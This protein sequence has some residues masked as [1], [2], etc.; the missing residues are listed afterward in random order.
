MD[1]TWLSS[2]AQTLHN[3]FGN[4]FYLFMTVLLLIGVILEYFKF[5]IGGTPQF[6]VLVGRCFIAALLLVAL[7]EVMD[8]LAKFTDSVVK[9]LGAFNVMHDVLQALGLK[10]KS[11]TWSWVGLKDLV[12]VAISA[13]SFFALYVTVYVGDAI[14]VYSWILLYVMSPVLIA[15]YVLPATAGATSALFKS[16]IHVCAWKILWCVLCSLMW[17]FALSDINKPD[18]S[19]NFLTAI[20]VNLMLAISVLMVPKV[21]SGFLSGGISGVADGIGNTLMNAASLTPSSVA[22][23]AMKPVRETK[24]FGKQALMGFPK[25]RAA[26]NAK[27]RAEKTRNKEKSED[28][29][30]DDGE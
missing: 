14:F 8:L 25:Q 15:L 3:V 9:D 7:P 27:L 16:L 22:Q 21:T 20:L 13:L 17:S 2:Q 1:T 30:E 24:N 26:R 5:A 6:S 23:N 19:V 29:L 28:D 10:C 11:L 12:M 18:S 4:L